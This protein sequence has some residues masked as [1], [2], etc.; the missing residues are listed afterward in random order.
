[1]I[2]PQAGDSMFD[3]L[4]EVAARYR[5]LEAL[6]AQPGIATNPARLKRSHARAGRAAS[7][8]PGLRPLA[9]ARDRPEP[10]TAS[11]CP[12]PDAGDPGAGPRRDRGV[13][14]PRS[15]SSRSASSGCLIPRR[16]RTTR[17]VPC[18]RSGRETGGD[19]AAL[20]AADLFRM[21]S[22]YAEGPWLE[23]RAALLVRDG[24]GW[25]QGG[26]RRGQRPVTSTA[27]SAARAGCTGSSAY[28]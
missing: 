22:R 12:T 14:R 9:R 17:R 27:R 2:G 25:L 16:I 3:R 6:L 23:G 13:S 10:R 18:S 19:E 26:L 7:H 21:Y 8:G 20:F 24:W 15:P 5:E 11:S 28:P 4:E 1:M